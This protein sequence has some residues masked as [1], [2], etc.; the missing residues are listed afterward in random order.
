[1]AQK[2]IPIF[3][4]IGQSYLSQHFCTI[5]SEFHLEQVKT[6]VVHL[7]DERMKGMIMLEMPLQIVT[8]SILVS[9]PEHDWIRRK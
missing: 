2:M 5:H 1:M 8:E 9:V 3:Y 4:R 6:I 7:V